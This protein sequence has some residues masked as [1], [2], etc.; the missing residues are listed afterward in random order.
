MSKTTQAVLVGLGAAIVVGFLL[1]FITSL[2]GEPNYGEAV[3]GGLFA[4]IAGAFIFGNLAGNRSIASASQAD[5][6][7]ALA[8]APP[9]GK[10]LV[11]IYR[12]AYVGKLVGM[13]VA[14]DGRPVAQIKS[15][16]FTKVAVSAGRHV[17]SAGFGGFA[18]AQVRQEDDPFDFPPGT[19][20][21]LKV[22]NRVG[23]VRGG[24]K[25]EIQPDLVAAKQRLARMPMTPADVPEL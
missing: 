20:I 9:E 21:V 23:L 6:T 16:R 11:Y 17:L 18:A 13:N 2:G 10:A 22:A 3:V 5:K 19:T 15:P 4:G 12:D 24:L 8:E 1:G 7:A 25:F 14:I